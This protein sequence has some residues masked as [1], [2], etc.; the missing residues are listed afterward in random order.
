MF[1][2][3]SLFSSSSV[4]CGWSSLPC[5]A[6]ST[7]SSLCYNKEPGFHT[8]HSFANSRW[9]LTLLITHSFILFTQALSSILLHMHQR[10]GNAGRASSL[11]RRQTFWWWFF[12]HTS[13]VAAFTWR[14]TIDLGVS[15]VGETLKLSYAA[16]C[17]KKSVITFTWMPPLYQT[18]WVC[19]SRASD[20]SA[21]KEGGP[22][23][24]RTNEAAGIS[25]ACYEPTVCGAFFSWLEA[26]P[27]TSYYFSEVK[28]IQN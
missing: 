26:S 14:D 10:P 20:P 6:H 1:D 17:G 2:T 15:P 21:F 7:G 11:W 8:C 25:L 12:K 9:V 4:E 13:L 18:P 3:F 22:Q 23:G 28:G 16:E 27:S 24:S 19:H 5:S